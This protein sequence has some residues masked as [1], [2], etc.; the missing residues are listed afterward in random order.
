MNHSFIKFAQMKLGTKRYIL[1][2]ERNLIFKI[3]PNQ[4]GRNQNND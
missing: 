2:A 3:K 4:D 1:C